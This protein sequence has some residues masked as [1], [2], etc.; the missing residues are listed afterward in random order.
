MICWFKGL[1]EEGGAAQWLALLPH[2]AINAMDPDLIPDLGHC[3]YGVCTF[4]P[5]L[6]GFPLGALVSSHSLRC[7]G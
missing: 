7:A 4:S 2:N 6:C 5:C 3:L 1:S